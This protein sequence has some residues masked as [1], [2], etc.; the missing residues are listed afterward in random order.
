[1]IHYELVVRQEVPIYKESGTQYNMRREPTGETELIDLARVTGV[2]ASRVAARDTLF[3][4]ARTLVEP[5]D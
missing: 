3:A 5:T 4:V 1:M 2:A